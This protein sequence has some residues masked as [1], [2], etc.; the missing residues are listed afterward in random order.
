MLEKELEKK[1][2]FIETERRKL[3]ALEKDYFK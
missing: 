2:K 1:E 3:K